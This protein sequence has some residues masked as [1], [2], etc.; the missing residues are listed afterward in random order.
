MNLWGLHHSICEEIETQFRDFVA[1]NWANPKAEFYIPTVISNQ[2][3]A[4]KITLKVLTSN[5]QW[6]GITYPEDKETV[7]QALAALR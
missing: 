7:Q 4:D 2:L 6:Y 3:K 5:S 1:A